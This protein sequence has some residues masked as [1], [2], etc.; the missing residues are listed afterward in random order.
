MNL[1][2]AVFRHDWHAASG[3]AG[4]PCHGCHPRGQ[5]RRASTASACGTCHNDLIPA[6]S[7]IPVKQYLAPSYT[8]AMHRLCVGCHAQMSEEMSGC[9]RCH[10]DQ[11]KFRE[12]LGLP[13]KRG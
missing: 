2:S 4:L 7:A 10:K 8:E 13:E 9:A 6:G 11:R 3:G 1:P 12:G 5:D